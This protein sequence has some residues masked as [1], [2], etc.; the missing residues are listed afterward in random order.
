VQVTSHVTGLLWMDAMRKRSTSIS[1]LTIR[2]I[3]GFVKLK[4]YEPHYLWYN[5][6]MET[7]V[8]SVPKTL[9]PVR[10]KARLVA[11]GTWVQRRYDDGTELVG[12]ALVGRLDRWHFGV[13]EV[14]ILESDGR[15]YVHLGRVAPADRVL[16]VH[17]E[18]AAPVEIADGIANFVRHLDREGRAVVLKTD[19]D[20]IRAVERTVLCRWRLWHWIRRM[21][22]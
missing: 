5:K 11:S 1:T 22:G 10:H 12:L 8:I 18:S 7:D 20:E 4:V 17:V 2:N 21:P 19:D 16:E 13:R 15:P 6:A 9:P 3:E 14:H